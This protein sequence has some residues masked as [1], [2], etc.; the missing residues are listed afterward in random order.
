[1]TTVPLSTAQEHFRKLARELDIAITER[2]HINGM[3]R[4]ANERVLRLKI[5][6]N[7]AWGELEMSRA[8]LTAGQRE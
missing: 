1:M 4:D 8:A 5:A 3:L 2:S 6:K 7:N